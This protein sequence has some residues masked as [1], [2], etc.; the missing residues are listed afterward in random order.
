MAQYIEFIGN[1]PYLTGSFALLL[2][3]F[4]FFELS[5]GGK[6]I[7]IQEAVRMIN[8]ENALV[9]DLRKTNEFQ[10]G[11][12][13]GARNIPVA[14]FKDKEH[15][16]DNQKKRPIIVA[17]NTGGSSRAVSEKLRASG[18]N[19]YRLAGGMMEWQAQALPMS[20]KL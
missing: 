19:A 8:R 2:V 10:G 13:A 11:H 20:K 14:T 7:D 4:I 18:F 16:L 17:C 5:R 12:I 1:H 15:T 9:L 6:A 3:A